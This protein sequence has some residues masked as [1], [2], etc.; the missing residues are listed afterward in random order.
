MTEPGLPKYF[1]DET[2]IALARILVLANLPVVHPGHPDLLEVPRRTF[3]VDWIPIVAAKGLVV[4]TRDRLSRLAE[5]EDRE[6]G[7]RVIR[8]A[9]KKNMSTWETVRV[10]ADA[11]DRIEH[12]VAGGGNGPWLVIIDGSG[13]L[14][15]RRHVTS[16]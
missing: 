8:L 11:W 13:T 9:G 14:R 16:A 2:N 12:Q 4:I 5:W 1:V 15:V 10:V 3:D 7:L 6:A